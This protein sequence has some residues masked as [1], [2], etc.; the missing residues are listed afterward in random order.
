MCPNYVTSRQE[1]PQVTISDYE[2]PGATFVKLLQHLIYNVVQNI[3]HNINCSII[4]NVI[5][6]VNHNAIYNIVHNVI[7]TVTNNVINVMKT[8]IDMIKML[9]MSF[10]MVCEKI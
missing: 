9:L 6:N 10:K 5:H 8:V 2:R 4:H 7:Y 3:I 1:Q